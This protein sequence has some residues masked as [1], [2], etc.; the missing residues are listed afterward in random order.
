M[1][2]MK[3]MKSMQSMNS[4]H[5][6]LLPSSNFLL[7]LAIS[8]STASRAFKCADTVACMKMLQRL[9][10][11]IAGKSFPCLA[12]VSWG[13]A[14]N[15]RFKALKLDEGGPNMTTWATPQGSHYYSAWNDNSVFVNL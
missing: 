14:S 11:A 3:S 7:P 12:V 6:I 9:L 13:W 1:Q 5:M 2:S 8:Q 4:P 10:T 15:K